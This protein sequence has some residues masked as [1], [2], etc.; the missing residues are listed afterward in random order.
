[1]SPLVWNAQK[2]AGIRVIDEQHGILL[3]GLNELRVALKLGEEC[4]V[5]RRLLHR[6]TELARLHVASEERLLEQHHFPGLAE[7]KA[8]RQLL[9]DQLEARPATCNSGNRYRQADSVYEL[10]EFLRT[11][12]VGHME[13]AGA[14]YGPWLQEHGVR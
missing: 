12:F 13:A 4:E 10:A 1:M 14:A 7:Y 2:A 5:V 11:W 8:E 9:L 3:D 6:V